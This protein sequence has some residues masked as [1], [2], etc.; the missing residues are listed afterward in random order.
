MPRFTPYEGTKPYLFISYARGDN[1]LMLETMQPVRSRRYRL[2][3]DEGIPGGNDWPLYIANH[4]QKASSVVFFL[5]GKSMVSPNCYSEMVAAVAQKKPI[6]VLPLDENALLIRSVI[7]QQRKLT[8]DETE[9]IHEATKE[10]AQ[11]RK[12]AVRLPE[13]SDWVEV[14]KNVSFSEATGTA[15]LLSASLLKSHVLNDSFIGDYVQSAEQTRRINAWL[16]ALIGCF[17]L[18]GLLLYG[19]YRLYRYMETQALDAANAPTPAQENAAGELSETSIDPALIPLMDK[20]VSFPDTLQER[21]VRRIVGISEDDIHLS[22]LRTI[23]S[24]GFCGKTVLSGDTEGIY[25][26]DHWSV[27]GITVTRG[28]IQ[29]L[30]VIENMLYLEDLT[31]I[32]QDISNIRRLKDLP[33]LKTLNLA[34]NPLTSLDLS[35]GFTHLTSLDISHTDIS[36]L[37]RIHAPASLRVVYVSVDMLPLSLDK[38]A[39]YEVVL[40]P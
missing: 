35:D 33:M 19:S 10:Y 5:S 36:D 3:Y 17:V 32:Y 16:F 8:A 7:R 2:W 20:A 6:L 30:S 14:L 40:V 29:D 28:S 37:T 11:R 15:T 38:T 31:L 25:S 23:T 27:N 26:D 21:A 24:L 34:G 9:K 13:P 18:L 4:L 1:E 39:S 12:T 22:D